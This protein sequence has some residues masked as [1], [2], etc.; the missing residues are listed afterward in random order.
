[1]HGDQ[2]RVKRELLGLVS[3]WHHA[4]ELPDGQVAENGPFYGTRLNSLENF[5]NG[6]A[7]EVVAREM[8]MAER[9]AAVGRARSRIGEHAYNPLSWNCEHYATWCAT[10]VAE[11]WQAIQWLGYLVKTALV[12]SA[13]ALC[14]TLRTA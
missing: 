6:G 2:L 3:G 7:V 12:V 8:T 14:M 4:V 11:S 1:M 10:G 13:A 9:D 5:A